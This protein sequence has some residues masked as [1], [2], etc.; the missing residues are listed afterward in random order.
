[1]AQMDRAHFEGRPHWGKKNWATYATLSK[2]YDA[3]AW[4]RFLALRAELDPTGLFLNDYL[5]T[6]L[7]PDDAE[8]LVML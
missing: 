7:I 6:R 3:G 4:T 1:M 2:N 5:R 8:R